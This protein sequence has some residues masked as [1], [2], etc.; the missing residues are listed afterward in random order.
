MSAFSKRNALRQG[1][2]LLMLAVVLSACGN[3]GIIGPD[4]DYVVIDDELQEFRVGK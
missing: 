1:G 4:E 3:G 2:L